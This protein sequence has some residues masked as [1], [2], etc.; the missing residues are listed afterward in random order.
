ML[1]NHSKAGR[2]LWEGSLCRR[3]LLKVAAV[4]HQLIEDVTTLKEEAESPQELL[5]LLMLPEYLLRRLL[6]NLRRCCT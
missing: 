2:R 5:L 3:P 1:R 4:E 6:E